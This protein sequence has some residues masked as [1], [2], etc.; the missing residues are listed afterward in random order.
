MKRSEVR[1]A[2]PATRFVAVA[3]RRVL[4][5]KA[6]SH[7][8]QR[9][10]MGRQA[11]LD[12]AQT[13]APSPPHERHGAELHAGQRKIDR[14]TALHRGVE[15]MVDDVQVFF[16]TNTVTELPKLQAPGR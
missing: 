11:R 4:E 14:W 10:R 16:D 3:Q 2:A 6:Q 15:V 5:W 13:P 8:E 7:R 9:G 1:P 12:V